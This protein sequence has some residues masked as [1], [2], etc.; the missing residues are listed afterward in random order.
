M[1]QCRVELNVPVKPFLIYLMFTL[2]WHYYS[3]LPDRLRICV[4]Q[5]KRF[6]RKVRSANRRGIFCMHQHKS[7]PR[8]IRKKLHPYLRMH[9]PATNIDIKDRAGVLFQQNQYVVQGI[10]NSFKYSSGKV[11][12]AMMESEPEEIPTCSSIPYR[13]ALTTKIGQKDQSL[14]ACWNGLQQLKNT[15]VTS[16]VQFLFT[17]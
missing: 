5:A 15:I 16:I 2:I 4:G 10:A 8:N 1:L 3:F 11:S 6:R 14:T 12:L 17:K 9:K 7:L 13:C